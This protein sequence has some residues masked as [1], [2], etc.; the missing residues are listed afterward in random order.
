MA[1][2]GYLFN[3]VYYNPNLVSPGDVPKTYQD[4]LKP[5]YTGKIFMGVDTQAA[6]VTGLLGATFG[7]KYYLKLG[8]QVRVMNTSGRGVADQI[9]AGTVP[10]G[11]ELSS[12][13]YKR[14]FVDKGA[15]IRLQVLNPMWGTY[16]ASSISKHTS[17]P[18][19]SML[20]VD[21]LSSRAAKGAIPIFAQLGNALPFKGSDVIPFAIAGQLPQSKWDIK[22]QTSSQI[23]KKLGFK[24]WTQL[25]AYWSKQYAEHFING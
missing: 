3:G 15:P 5:Q 7:R 1:S 12:S 6:I 11:L 17:K 19:A 25:Y 16:Q 10:M 23:R 20:L 24:N 9:I 14:D 8:E 13:Y 2:N 18:C 21:W 4:L 22:Y